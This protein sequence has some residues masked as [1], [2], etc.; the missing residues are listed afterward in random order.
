MRTLF[1]RRVIADKY[2]LDRA[3]A[4]GGMG[5][6]WSAWNT[7]LDIPV[8]IKFM[9]PAL[10][11]SPELVA[12]FERE[13][14]AAAQ[15]RSAHVVQIFEHGLDGGQP[16]IVMELLEG[17][18]LGARMRREG[19]LRLHETARI[20]EGVCRAL[21]RAHGLGIV[22]RDLK[23][24]N[25]F[26][27]RADE[28]DDEDVVKVLDFG[29][30]KSLAEA[31]ESG[32]TKTGEIIG[33]PHYMSPEQA[34][35]TRNVDHRSDLWSLG[36]IAYR[37]LT[38]SLPF[39]DD[40]GIGMLLRACSEHAPPPSSF[41]RDLGAD[42]DAFFDRAL[43]L[44]PEDRFHTAREMADAMRQ[45]A[46]LPV[47]SR[48]SE[49]DRISS[50]PGDG[51]RSSQLYP[52]LAYV[53]ASA[54]AS[55]DPLMDATLAPRA[56]RASSLEDAAIGPRPP[57]SAT[58]DPHA[59]ATLPSPSDAVTRD[60]AILAADLEQ[61]EECVEVDLTDE[62]ER[63]RRA[64]ATTRVSA[65]DHCPRPRPS[66]GSM[67]PAPLAIV[68]SGP[69]EEGA[70]DPDAP[71]EGKVGTSS[72]AGVERDARVDPL[73]TRAPRSRV[74]LLA[75]SAALVLG[76]IAVAFSPL[77]ESQDTRATSPVLGGR[78]SWTTTLGADL[79]A[80]APPLEVA[81]VRDVRQS[82]PRD[83]ARDP[84][85]PSSDAPIAGEPTSA[86]TATAS[87]SAAAT[88]RP[89]AAPPPGRPPLRKRLGP[90]PPPPRPTPR[91]GRNTILPAR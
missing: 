31:V 21:R 26:L 62:I 42:V 90:A 44:D 51:P 66:S 29:V 28:E 65:Q 69:A 19:R 73:S 52:S 81:P 60:A 4:A 16:F 23:P 76:A 45:L 50:F 17:E 2:V 18:D 49:R 39:P 87:A 72:Y 6:V 74:A 61:G 91:M 8:A 15:L 63:E 11:A 79:V 57:R 9:A 25:V 86:P 27:A 55:S 33:T 14:R 88:V 37:A 41:A 75:A 46:G 82:L 53:Y 36:I 34:K 38:A 24:A 78:L 20:V 3:L 84:V 71:T 10:A 43:A 85:A 67:R 32:V 77:A 35:S 68:R 89:A 59:R 22:H 64:E 58:L 70:A 54:A 7:Q 48:G 80:P 12:R 30:V 5:S 56:L 47:S 13:A 1:A 83:A 40:D